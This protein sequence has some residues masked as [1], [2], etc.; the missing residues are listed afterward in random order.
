ALW[1]NSAECF[2]YPSVFEGFG[3]PVLEAM[4]CG[5]PVLTSNVSSLPEVAEGAGMCLPPHEP[6]A[7]MIALREA[8]AEWRSAARE[9]GLQKAA[10]FQWEDTARLT[11][12]SYQQALG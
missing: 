8:N 6:D 12:S 5:T 7:W 1:Y 3:L 11:V 10:Q 2:L 4:A 9:R